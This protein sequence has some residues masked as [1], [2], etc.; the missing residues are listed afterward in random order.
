MLGADERAGLATIGAFMD[1]RATGHQR[2]LGPRSPIREGSP[3]AP[4]RHIRH[5]GYG[6]TRGG[7]GHRHRHVAWHSDGR[8][9]LLLLAVTL[10]PLAKA[11][12]HRR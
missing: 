5:S 2:L 11:E 4:D 3:A 9:V 1:E 7:A 12:H 10:S 8:E 6:R